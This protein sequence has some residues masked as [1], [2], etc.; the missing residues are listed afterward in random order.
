MDMEFTNRNN[1]LVDILEIALLEEESGNVYHSYV[2][3]NYSISK[4]MQLLTGITNR[5]IETRRVPFRNAMYG[6]VESIR[7]EAT[8]PAIM[9]SQF[10][11][12]LCFFLSRD[13]DNPRRV[14]STGKLHETQ[15]QRLYSSSISNVP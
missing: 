14:N 9:T 12:L 3:M 10:L 4:Q 5:T 7:R 2:K 8:T 1:Y 15:L 11:F 6:H 13:D